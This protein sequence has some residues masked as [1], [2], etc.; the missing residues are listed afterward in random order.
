M[1]YRSI[2]FVDDD[3]M[4]QWTMTDVLTDAGFDVSSV[5]RGADALALM[6]RDAEFD[7]LLTELDL[8]DGLTGLQLAYQW[9]QRLSNR[10]VIFIGGAGSFPL[11]QLGTGDMFFEKPFHTG[12]LLEAIVT[13]IDDA[14]Y[15]PLLRTPCW[16]V[17]QVH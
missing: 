16:P 4:T 5:C 6:G 1:A 3:V 7:V 15:R 14:R 10:P 8:P 12:R 17:H 13:A 11:G 9:R 2:L